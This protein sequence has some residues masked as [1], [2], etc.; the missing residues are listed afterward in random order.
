MADIPEL[1]P[2]V[3]TGSPDPSPAPW[4]PWPTFGPIGCPFGFIGDGEGGCWPVYNPT[5]YEPPPEPEAP[6]EPAPVM[7]TPQAAD[8]PFGIGVAVSLGSLVTGAKKALDK[9]PALRKR[10]DTLLSRTV[11]KLTGA[12]ARREAAALNAWLRDVAA[13]KAR[14]KAKGI[15]AD[16]AS[17]IASAEATA[18]GR[19]AQLEAVVQKARPGLAAGAKTLARDTLAGALA[20]GIGT[21]FADQFKKPVI[22][23]IN[24]EVRTL[25]GETE[26]LK[27]FKPTSGEFLRGEIASRRSQLP[28]ANPVR[29]ASSR[30][31][32]SYFT[33]TVSRVALG[34][35]LA[36]SQARFGSG[37]VALG[38]SLPAVAPLPT[39]F[40]PTRRATVNVGS[41]AQGQRTR[42]AAD[43]LGTALRMV[44]G[45][46]RLL[47]SIR[48]T[49][50]GSINLPRVGATSAVTPIAPVGS[51]II[52]ALPLASPFSGGSAGSP[53][54][55]TKTAQCDCKKKPSKKKQPRNVCYRGTYT[56]RAN[57]LT[58][59]KKEKIPCR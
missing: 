45:A 56:E 39:G 17:R 44:T 12:T 15:S 9:Y 4:S 35:A 51:P 48:S 38:L 53:P 31:Q 33:P 47:T 59:L 22:R 46:D 50:V 11:G 36:R 14:L 42:N 32:L 23:R 1:D 29:A 20:V 26:A 13:E 2:V 19:V 3:I 21:Y 25:T 27:R 41:P 18:R 10:I 5:P 24:G 52:S 58:K 57:G 37:A 8:I 30:A 6:P 40:T 49:G 16:F 43:I 54:T 55:R 7:P 34:D 28:A